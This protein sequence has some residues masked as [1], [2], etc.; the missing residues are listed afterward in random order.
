MKS[1]A[2]LAARQCGFGTTTPKVQ[3]PTVAENLLLI[4]DHYEIW[5]IRLLGL[6]TLVNLFTYSVNYAPTLSA[7]TLPRRTFK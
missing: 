6:P 3:F 4:N 5:L 1:V 2:P 7:P